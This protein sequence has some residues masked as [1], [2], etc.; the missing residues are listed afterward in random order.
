VVDT[1]T[2][3]DLGPSAGRTEVSGV[4][5]IA[6]VVD[7]LFNKW[8]AQVLWALIHVGRLRFSQLR[9]HLPGVTPK[10]LSQRLRQLER[11][12]LL[13]RTYHAEVP[14]RVEYEATALALSL[15]PV[16]AVLASWSDDHAP[17]IQ[18]ARA[19]YT[20]PLVA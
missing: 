4:C 6:P 16:F 12:G 15:G 11:D 2:P 7:V 19:A 13:T 17:D 3:T 14:P 1:R 5:P 10:V 8:T 9:R 18:T 20:G